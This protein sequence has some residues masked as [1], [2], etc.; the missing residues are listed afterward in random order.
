MKLAIVVPRYG[1]GVAGGAETVARRVAHLLAE[2]HRVTV[3]TTTASDYETWANDLPPGASDDAAV[4]VLRFPVRRQRGEYWSRLDRLLLRLQGG[5]EFS[6]L[7]AAER[8]HIRRQVSRWPMALQEEYVRRQG[9]DAPALL[10]WLA[11]HGA[12]HERVLFFTYLYPTT[13]FGMRRVRREAIDFYPALHDEPT[14]YLPAFGE[15][16]RRADRILF[17]TAEELRWAQTLHGLAPA[18]SHVV[19]CGMAE[20]PPAGSAGVRRDPFVLYVGRIDIN[21]GVPGLV[22]DFIRWKD[23]QRGGALRLILIGDRHVELPK[24]PAVEYLGQVSEEDKVALLRDAVALVHPSPFESLGLVLLE[25]FWCATPALVFGGNHVLVAHCR[26]SN[27]GLW[28]RDQAELVAALEWLEGHP[29]EA[30]ELGSQ[31]REYVRC[32]YS[33]DAYRARLAAL[34]PPD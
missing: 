2:W 34:Y 3:L 4:R 18:C 6:T 24:H 27:G 23:E 16:F 19:G 7:R 5:R 13:Y 32:E 1:E 10:T 8:R 33:L 20:P 25:A 26:A 15:C 12:D 22:R 9:P 21:K 17:G 14:A 28:Y 11:E 30:G 31:A 29:A